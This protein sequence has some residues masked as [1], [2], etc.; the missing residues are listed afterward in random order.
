MEEQV[1]AC[2]EGQ[3]CLHV[4]DVPSNPVHQHQT[5]NPGVLDARVWFG[6]LIGITSLENNL[7]IPIKI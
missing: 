5:P 4:V 1:S 7:A 3:M 2:C 6:I